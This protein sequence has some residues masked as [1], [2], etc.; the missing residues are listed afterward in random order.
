MLYLSVSNRI[1]ICISQLTC[2]VAILI[3]LPNSLGLQR[4]LCFN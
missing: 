1:C 3:G 4:P 2:P